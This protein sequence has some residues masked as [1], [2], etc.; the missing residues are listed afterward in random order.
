M[1]I[2]TKPAGFQSS[3]TVTGQTYSRRVDVAVMSALVGLGKRKK[4]TWFPGKFTTLQKYSTKIIRSGSTSTKIATDIRL[5]AHDK[6]LE[7][8]FEASQVRSPNS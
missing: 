8:P 4:P 1:V 2:V 7:E 3:Y 6:E 5:L